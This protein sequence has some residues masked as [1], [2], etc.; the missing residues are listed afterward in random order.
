M[1]IIQKRS[2]MGDVPVSIDLIPLR[3]EQDFIQNGVMQTRA[4]LP[5]IDANQMDI[6]KR[7]ADT[8]SNPKPR[9]W[10]LSRVHPADEDFPVFGK[11]HAREWPMQSVFL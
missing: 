11:P 6:G 7:F 8:M 5:V 9:A 3:Q 2:N 4:P 10:A 1:T